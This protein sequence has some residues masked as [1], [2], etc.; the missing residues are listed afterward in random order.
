M[1]LISNTLVFSCGY[2]PIYDCGTVITFRN[3]R[4]MKYIDHVFSALAPTEK[5]VHLVCGM[6]KQFAC[7]TAR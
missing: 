4:D 2:R 5:D 6:S 1:E 7:T 3:P